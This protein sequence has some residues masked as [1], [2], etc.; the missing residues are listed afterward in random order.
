MT[1]DRVASIVR[2]VVAEARRGKGGNADLAA[3]SRTLFA[4]A[5]EEDLAPYQPQDLARLAEESLSFIDSRTPGRPKIRSRNPGD[6]LQDATIIEIANDDMPFLVDSVLGLLNERGHEIRLL[7]HPVL[8]VR[9]DA[10]GKLIKFEEKSPLIADLMRESFM[11]IHV[12]RIADSVREALERE[13]ETALKDVRV[14]VL[15]WNAMQVRLKVAITNYQSSPPPIPV[16]DVSESIAFLQWLLDNHFTF[17]GMREYRFEGGAK[18]GQLTPVEGSGLGIL[19]NPETQVLRKGGE[20][21]SITPEVRAFLMQPAALIITKSDVRAN[22]HR[23]AAMDYIGVK[24]FNKQGELAGE[25]RVVGLFTS[26]AYTRSPSSVPLIR[27]KLHSVIEASGFN[28]SGHSG[29][30]LLNVL[31][32]FPRD[33]LFQI[34]SE[35]LAEIAHGIL[36]LEERPR[37]RLFVRRDRFDRFVSAF[38]FIPRDRFNSEVRQRVGEIIA[39][40]FAGRAVSFSPSFGEST[41]V[42]VHYIILRAR[43]E[44]PKP[45]LTKLEAQVVEAVRTWDDRLQSEL[46]R[47]EFAASVQKWRG[48]FPAGYRERVTPRQSL[49]DVAELENLAESSVAVEFAQSR[50]NETNEVTLRLYRFGEAIPLS[51]RLPI[52]ENM[53]FKAIE[54]TTYDIAPQGTTAVIHD[55][56]LRAD[57][58]RVDIRSRA[59]A[60]ETTFMAV[61]NGIAENDGFNALTLT[62]GMH[63]RDVVLLRSF[64]R[65]LRQ[66]AAGL[67]A[68]YMAQ[69]LVKHSAIAAKI[70]DMFHARFDPRNLDE[71]KAQ[72]IAGEIEEGLA[73]V[74]AL[75]EDRI[76]RAYCS[77]VDGIVRTGFFQERGLPEIISFK[78]DS[79][80]I[81]GLPEPK[82]FAEIFVYSPDMEGLHLRF[83]KIARGGIRWSDRQEDYRREILGL[84]KAQNVKNAVIIPVGAKGGFVPKKLQAGTSR[85]QVQ[86][87]GVRAY[88][89][90]VSSLL[91]ITDNLKG[92]SIVSPDNVVRRDGDDPYMVVAADKGTATFSDIANEISAA[93]DFWLDDAFA[94]GGSAGYDHKKMGITA[95]GAWEAVKRHFREMDIDIE[96]TPIT[97]TGIG[98]MSGDVFGNGMLLSRHLKLVAAFDHR[99]IFIDPEPDPATSFE[100]RKRLFELPRSSWQDYDRTLIS[101]GGGIFS[102]GLKAIHLSG[103]IKGLTGLSGATATP[104]QVMNALLRAPVDL[105]WFGGIGTFIK[106]SAENNSEVGDRANDGIRVNATEVRAKV[107]GEGANL[108]VTQRGRVEYARLGG[109]INT[110][111]IDNSAGVNSSD[112]EVNLK[113]ALSVAEREG[114]IDRAQRNRLLEEMSEEVGELVLR[115]NY[116]QT[117]S[118][119]LAVAH[120]TE[121][122]SYAILLMHDLEAAGL[123]DRDLESLPQD[124]EIKTRDAR[125]ETLTRPEFA[126]LL[127]YA[128]IA[129]KKDLRESDVPDD[130][131]LSRELERYFPQRMVGTHEEEIKR[132]RLRRE[133]IATT[134]ANSIIN[135][136][137]PGFV[138]RLM[139]ETGA[140]AA[141]IAA[142]FAVAR[143]SFD[144]TTHN[145]AIDALDNRISA[146]LQTSLYLEL[147]ALLRRATQ[148]F[149]R[150]SDLQSGLNEIVARYRQGIDEL[151]ALLM[152]YLPPDVI[153]ALERRAAELRE[154]GVPEELARRLASLGYL[155]RAPD[156]VQVA[157]ECR[158]TLGA[159]ARVLFASG[160]YFDID[161][162]LRRASELVAKDFF[163]RLA[164]NRTIDQLF[165]AQRAITSR[166]LTSHGNSSDPFA[167][168]VE[169]YGGRIKAVAEMVR[170]FASEEPFDL[171]KLSVAQGLL[172]DLATA[173]RGIR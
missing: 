49:K 29:K 152:D 146:T 105:I 7:L 170:E 69:T 45:D 44:D 135:R 20:L 104:Q 53:G 132:H 91:D 100:E 71:A 68:D 50:E 52:L 18:K 134:L 31:E 111:A 33:E 95:R 124:A 142:A 166:V 55:V 14:A 119:S 96:S 82:P 3:F 60:L 72:R 138:A 115:N 27:R 74:A 84:A 43:G 76:I 89:S 168:W 148:W 107:I 24:L 99:D 141:Q 126:V 28:P 139:S 63:W 161:G 4:G 64:A 67:S 40:A 117:L 140:P 102:R 145:R 110:D 5:A 56:L 35:S 81:E 120:G 97:V 54:E 101:T 48:A 125:R 158:S 75:D 42:R 23:R 36:R 147:Q 19:R 137:G 21:V 8:N 70:V 78:I 121:E 93:H 128:K 47:A 131:Y 58:P 30:A 61:W 88:R 157:T 136:G 155:Q 16:E 153:E 62:E 106:S 113:I 59:K 160:A 17:L 129:L 37:T 65:Y 108:G 122:N 1:G 150:N 26:T 144:L 149:L 77:L 167:A 165:L 6:A 9:R 86:A 79:K 94:S 171:A 173:G 169:A 25:L 10:Q 34:D 143:D 127:A 98:D 162:L 11:H 151:K 38:A 41:L 114:K 123:L 133:I 164:I 73:K 32:T 12:E 163:E 159:A 22:V 13:I 172:W 154:E 80:K 85:E 112:M 15:D 109:R 57:G 2:N 87:E 92:E 83:G 46:T 118:M 156:I 90:F 66:G 103:Q 116:L 39:T 130:E 51:N